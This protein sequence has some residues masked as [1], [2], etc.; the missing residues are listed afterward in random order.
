M[1]TKHLNSSGI[2]YSLNKYKICTILFTFLL[3]PS[4]SHA[5]YIDWDSPSGI[6]E[7]VAFNFVSAEGISTHSYIGGATSDGL[8]LGS[9]TEVKVT[10][11]PVDSSRDYQMNDI[12]TRGFRIRKSSE[13][14]EPT[15]GIK[16]FGSLS[17]TLSY[18]KSLYSTVY[19]SASIIDTGLSITEYYTSA[20]EVNVPVEFNNSKAGTL[21]VDT[22]YTLVVGLN[23]GAVSMWDGSNAASAQSDFLHTATASISIVPEPSTILLLGTGFALLAVKR[24]KML[25]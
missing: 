20:G 10:G 6:T 16:L 13:D 25:A 22:L 11:G 2:Q 1:N 8:F 4:I 12:I 14:E 19:F 9:L 21:D 3:T 7:S 15:T 17:G 24:R 23:T 18:Q 5:Y